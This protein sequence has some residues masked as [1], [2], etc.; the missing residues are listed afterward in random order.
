MAEPPLSKWAEDWSRALC[1]PA[2]R[3]QVPWDQLTPQEQQCVADL[4]TRAE[5]AF[6]AHFG[7]LQAAL[8]GLQQWDLV[9]P[10]GQ[11]GGRLTYA[12]GS[13]NLCLHRG[14]GQG[15]L[16]AVVGQGQ[17]GLTT[18]MALLPL[19]GFTVQPAQG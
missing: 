3:E 2:G 19:L 14:P 1:L 16:C 9:G 7:A 10:A 18:A 8:P 6:E 17:D 4:G 5:T 12:D 13:V 11:P 15:D